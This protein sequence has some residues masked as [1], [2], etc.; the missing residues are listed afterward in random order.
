MERG[1]QGCPLGFWLLQLVQ[2]YGQ[3]EGQWVQGI[4]VCKQ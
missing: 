2:T 4:C 1:D 3:L